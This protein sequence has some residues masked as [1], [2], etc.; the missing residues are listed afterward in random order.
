MSLVS[1]RR[2]RRKSQSLVLL[3]RKPRDANRLVHGGHSCE[4]EKCGEMENGREEDKVEE[5]SRR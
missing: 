1:R 4:T 5:Q 3:A 2:R